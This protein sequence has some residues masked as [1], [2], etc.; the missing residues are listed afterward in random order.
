MDEL[1]PHHRPAAALASVS[2]SCRQLRHGELACCLCV[3][4]IALAAIGCVQRT[5]QITSD[6]PGSLVY[7]N[8]EEVGRTPLTVPFLFYGVYDVRLEHE[9][10]KPL[11]TQQPTQTPWWE[12]PGP[13][14]IAEMIPNLKT[15]QHWHYILELAPIPSE[16]PLIDRAHQLRATLNSPMASKPI[17]AP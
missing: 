8:D 6:P 4:A 11:W 12:A 14:L 5:I 2:R 17:T 1:T 9:G 10:Y 15:Q 13:D 3:M 16:T 7:L